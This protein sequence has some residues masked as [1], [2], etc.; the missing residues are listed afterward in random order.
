MAVS[1]FDMQLVP[2]EAVLA[3]SKTFP[4]HLSPQAFED[5]PWCRADNEVRDLVSAL[6]AHLDRAKSWSDAIESWGDEDG[7]VATY[8]LSK[9]VFERLLCA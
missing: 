8:C 5:L 2:S 1:Q 6:A 7:T 4:S 3:C 9:D